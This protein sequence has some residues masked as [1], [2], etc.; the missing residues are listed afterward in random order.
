M[1]ELHSVLL[2]Q[3]LKIAGPLNTSLFSFMDWWIL[4]LG[5]QLTDGFNSI[6]TIALHITTDYY[7]LPFPVMSLLCQQLL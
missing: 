3:S 2:S 7:M 4:W 6:L 5:G 1:S